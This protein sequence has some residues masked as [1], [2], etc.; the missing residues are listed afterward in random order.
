MMRYFPAFFDMANARVVI[1]GSGALAARKA[2]ILARSPAEIYLV[3]SRPMELAYDEC[4]S[5]RFVDPEI[6]A[7]FLPDTQFA[8]VAEED[9]VN[10]AAAIALVR[11]HH[12]ALN[13]VNA[14]AESDFVF[15]SLIERGEFV[16]GVTSGGKAPALERDLR[17][18]FERS[19]PPGLAG[20]MA[21]AGETQRTLNKT[22]P[23]AAG[24][25][26]AWE[27]IS[28]DVLAGREPDDGETWGEWAE[29]RMSGQATPDSTKCGV[30]CLDGKEPEDS[31]LRTF[32]FLQTCD[33][34]IVPAGLDQGWAELIRRD[35][36][37]IVASPDELVIQ[38][39]CLTGR[40]QVACLVLTE[41]DAC[42]LLQFSE[43]GKISIFRL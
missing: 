20:F 18:R 13:V 43:H 21:E 17:G 31:T 9:P 39:S 16:V 3:G 35:A 36:D 22:I 10:R 29:A 32:R 30:L 33:L 5:L 1:F 38:L 27:V 25:R 19:L 15:P 37:R 23:D 14:P 34:A 41:Q 6:A 40:K 7:A 4:P 26:R 12:I 24:R 2:R 11:Y 8:I 42:N 28:R